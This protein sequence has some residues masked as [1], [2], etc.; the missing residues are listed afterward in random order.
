MIGATIFTIC[1][2][3]FWRHLKNRMSKKDNNKIM[4]NIEKY[5]KTRIKT[6]TGGLHSDYKYG[7]ANK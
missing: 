4:E 5:E 6:R 1:F 3:V 2:L 7:K